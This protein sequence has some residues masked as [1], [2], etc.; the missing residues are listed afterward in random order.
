MG[1]FNQCA[2]PNSNKRKITHSGFPQIFA[3]LEHPRYSTKHWKK[4]TC[5]RPLGHMITWGERLGKGKEIKRGAKRGLE[6]KLTCFPGVYNE[7]QGQEP[8][9]WRRSAD[10]SKIINVLRF[11]HH[12]RVLI[13][14]RQGLVLPLIHI[15]S[16]LW[17][18]LVLEPVELLTDSFL[19]RFLLAT[20]RLLL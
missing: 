16:L 17:D 10:I 1:N 8:R 5:C 7:Q 12:W 20:H 19:V 4:Y 3:C 11:H 2:S 6:K 15:S 9:H 14:Y 18:H 13:H